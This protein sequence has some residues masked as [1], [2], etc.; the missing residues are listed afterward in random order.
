ML[1]KRQ[2]KPHDPVKAAEKRVRAAE[3]Q[4]KQGQR[5]ETR[6]FTSAIRRTRRRT[7]IAVAT[8]LAL[9]L[10]VLVGAFTPIMAVRDV[11]IEGAQSVNVD[12]VKVALQRF[13]GTPLA[14]VDENEILKALSA[15]PLIQRFAVE[16][17]PPST[18]IVRI[19]ERVPAI[20]I[21]SDGVVR[22]YDAAG[23]LVGEVPERPEGVPLGGD[24]L[25]N[26]SGAAFRAA[27]KVVRDMPADLRQQTVSVNAVTGQD[28]VFVLANGIEV[29]WGNA[30][31]TKRKSLV[32]QTMLTSLEGRSVSH[33]DV[34][35]T[36]SPIFR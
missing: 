2:P 11:Q 24:S 18:L 17:V 26:T 4:N 23:V 16:R 33:I 36:D 15:F 28:V 20:A 29:F 14:L 25:R 31:D 5:R 30:N 22:L 9:V 19:E 27:S 34:S 21:E 10:F 12:D 35:S 8:V 7:L 13:E 32:L 6:R 1:P 3:R